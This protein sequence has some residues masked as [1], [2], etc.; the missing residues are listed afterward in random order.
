MGGSL[1]QRYLN[2]LKGDNACAVLVSTIVALPLVIYYGAI[3]LYKYVACNMLSHETRP[4]CAT[5]EVVDEILPK[6]ADCHQGIKPLTPVSVI[7]EHI[8]RFYGS[9]P[10]WNGR[11]TGG[12]MNKFKQYVTYGCSDEKPSQFTIYAGF[13]SSDASECKNDPPSNEEILFAAFYVILIL[14]IIFSSVEVITS[15]FSTKTNLR[16]A[17]EDDQQLHDDTPP[18]ND[19]TQLLLGDASRLHMQIDMQTTGFG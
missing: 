9:C 3:L 11:V 13:D 4:A 19:E 10:P 1:S 2:S 15:Y 5:F 16:D 6:G 18:P 12:A 17:N 7:K 14:V 8:A